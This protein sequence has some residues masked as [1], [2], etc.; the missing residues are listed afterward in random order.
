[1]DNYTLKI[2]HISNCFEDDQDVCFETVKMR[3]N[4]TNAV[5][6]DSIYLGNKLKLS[7]MCLHLVVL[8]PPFLRFLELRPAMVQST[9]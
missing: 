5:S 7:S 8:P 6:E 1:M 4:T 9:S 3:M 2:Y